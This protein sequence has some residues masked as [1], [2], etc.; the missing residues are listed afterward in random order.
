VP[1]VAPRMSIVVLPFTNLSD[2]RDQQYFVDAITE[3]LTTDLSRI[4]DSFVISRNTAFTYK[5][6]PVDAKQIGRELGVRYVLEGSVQRSGKQLRVN[7]QLI[8]A[9]TAAHV[10]AERFER[11]IGN[12]FALQTEV[13]GRIAVTLN[14]ELVSVEAARPT[15]NP[16]AL[17]Y[18]LRGRAAAVKPVSRD[19][20]AESIS[21]FERALALDPHSVEAQSLLVEA[22][23]GRVLAGMT[24]S[25]AADIARAEVLAGQALAAA[26]RSPLAHYARGNVLRAQ[27]QVLGAQSRYDEAIPEY[28][29]AIAL[30]RN[31]VRALHALGQCKFFAGLIEET[32]PLEEQAIR[33][34]P[35]D[36]R[37]G[38]WYSQIG[39]VH[40]LQSRTDEAIVWLEKARSAIPV[41]SSYNAYLAS[42][43]ALKG[44]SERAAA[45][46]AE[47]RRL[48]GDDRYTSIARLKAKV[49]FGVP[50]IRAMNE[51]TYF[52][53]L[54]KA[55]VPEE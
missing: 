30:D 22:L 34:S 15:E 20:Y 43:Y 31:G 23:T 33:L 37:L 4:A 46:L 17:D 44:D 2:E 26:P 55:G 35:R 8:D 53:G 12:L 49:Y 13:T 21:L 9:E 32:I 51:A 39:I 7:V 47:A 19:N 24:D 41:Y 48:T 27:A 11:D 10:W 42:A 54:R 38:I 6:K 14:L 50:K 5:E 1:S 40:L 52:A 25:V 28:E 3:D 18:I 45:A 36:S 29:T 16:D